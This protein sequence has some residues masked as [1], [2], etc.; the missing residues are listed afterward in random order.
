M[1]SREYLSGHRWQ[2]CGRIWI[3]EIAREREKEERENMNVFVQSPKTKASLAY[4]CR[5]RA[6]PSSPLKRLTF[7]TLLLLLPQS[8][9][10]CYSYR[11][12]SPSLFLSRATKTLHHSLSPHFPNPNFLT[13]NSFFFPMEVPSLSLYEQFFLFDCIVWFLR[14]PWE[15]FNLREHFD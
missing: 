9:N 12:L 8:Q 1:S 10:R 15:N 7:T 14:K 11:S 13:G 3:L 4:G 5:Y 6:H 2:P